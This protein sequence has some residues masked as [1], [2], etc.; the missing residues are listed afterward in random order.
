MKKD[1]I[2][3][4]WVV[5]CEAVLHYTLEKAG[6][7]MGVGDFHYVHNEILIA[8]E[9]EGTELL[10]GLWALRDICVDCLMHWDTTPQG[11]LFW[12]R[13]NSGIVDRALNKREQE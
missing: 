12:S 11:H 2:E 5:G 4:D 1:E 7:P 9:S 8:V 3:K 6:V 13:V 10:I